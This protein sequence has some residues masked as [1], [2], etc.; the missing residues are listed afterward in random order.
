MA[1]IT[2]GTVL[3]ANTKNVNKFG[4]Y[5]LTLIVDAST[6][7]DDLRSKVKEYEDEDGNKFDIIRITSKYPI[8][9]FDNDNHIIPDEIGRGSELVVKLNLD[10][11][12][13]AKGSVRLEAGKVKNLIKYTSKVEETLKELDDLELPF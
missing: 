7:D 3:F 11:R 12:F 5:Q 1:T 8:N 9:L 10:K 2:K 4:N 6:L 13:S